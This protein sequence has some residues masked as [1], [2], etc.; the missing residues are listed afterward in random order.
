MK[1]KA[2]AKV[3]AGVIVIGLI[4][5]A[6]IFL[7]NKSVSDWMKSAISGWGAAQSRENPGWKIFQT[8]TNTEGVYVRIVG[9]NYMR[10]D[11]TGIKADSEE[12]Q[13][14]KVSMLADGICND[15]EKRW[16]SENDWEDNEHW[17]QVHFKDQKQIRSIRLYWERLNAVKYSVEISR[18]G[19]EWTEAA[20]FTEAPD[21][22]CQDIVLE[23]CVEAEYLRLHVFD[24]KKEEEDASLYY[25]N[26]SLL[27]MEV[28]GDFTD[29]FVVKTPMLGSGED[30][31]LETPSV[32]EGYELQFVGSDYENVID[33]SG[34]A[35]DTLSDVSVE[36]GYRLCK[37]GIW[38]DLPA[39]EITVPSN[40]SAVEVRTETVDD[41]AAGDMSEKQKAALPEGY[42]VME[43]LAG[44]GSY[45]S[46][47]DCIIY[48][49]EDEQLVKSAE[50]FAEEWMALTG[51]N[52]TVVEVDEKIPAKEAGEQSGTVIETA[53]HIYLRYSD[54]I[55]AEE[56]YQLSFG[57]LYEDTTVIEG[58]DLQ[59][60]R[61]GCVSFLELLQK[62]EQI[63]RGRVWD[64]PRYEVRGFGID[65]ARRPVELELLY[66]M[67]EAMSAQKMNTLL[68]HLNDNQIISQSEHGGTIEG[69]RELYAAFRLESDITGKQ[70]VGLTA[71]DLYYTKEEFADFI[72]YAALYGVEVV[73]EI[74]TPAHSLAII[75]AFPQLGNTEDV[76]AADQLDLSQ[77]ETTELVKSIWSEYLEAESGKE[78][79]FADCETVHIGMDE[80]FGD[81]EEFISYI[82]E[83]S[84]HVKTLAPDKN[85]RMW[86]SLTGKECDYS[87]ISRDIEIQLWSTQW[88]DPDRMYEDG[89]S[90]INSQNNHLYIIPGSGYDRLDVEYLE[91]EWEVNV[92]ENETQRWEIP[93][94][95][96]QMLG[97]CYMMWND[98]IMIDG[99]EISREDL[100]DRF[101]E[102]LDVIADK[103]WN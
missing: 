16:S 64:Y 84:S 3:T 83:L 81:G 91:N 28:Y 9:E 59:G 17:I 48:V 58:R 98:M 57:T 87:E 36:I 72:R 42:E 89:F 62:T 50:I 66:R 44:V 25:Q 2:K 10:A 24:V 26:V 55:K 23:E 85:I 65:V 68:V 70:G 61:W 32:P 102:P 31:R 33:E 96:S 99:I 67:V 71:T 78:A 21:S 11:G 19:K 76:L 14:T 54:E 80:Y 1:K 94:Y 35:A 77:K 27:E 38:E 12:N 73:P 86:G 63:P 95:S 45:E 13:E 74:D 90:I 30:R 69:A 92:F 7:N 47:D 40:V 51:K 60:V 18:D 15:M 75:K 5:L 82:S 20:A 8:E 79:V 93:S 34:R 22:R 4:I 101:Y 43:W 97:A 56:G 88:A 46:A 49:E 52:A 41:T 100:W 53:G 39:M 37:D 29:E 6:V 103:L